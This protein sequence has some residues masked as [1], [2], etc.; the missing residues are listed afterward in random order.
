MFCFARACLLDSA[1]TAYHQEKRDT[2]QESV[3]HAQVLAAIL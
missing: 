3:G 1:N 2:R